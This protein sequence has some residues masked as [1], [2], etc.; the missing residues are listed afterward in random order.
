MLQ[1]F[2][3]ESADDPREQAFIM[4]GWVSDVM[5]W[6]SFSDAWKCVLDTAPRIDYFSHHEAMSLS[7]Q[8]KG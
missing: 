7:Q 1:A 8:F 2:F 5:T 4:A 6:R 3:D